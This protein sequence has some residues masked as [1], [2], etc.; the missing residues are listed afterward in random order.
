MDINEEAIGIYPNVAI[1]P[2]TGRHAVTGEP[3][4]QPKSTRIAVDLRDLPLDAWWHAMQDKKK[5]VAE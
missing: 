3:V 1:D 2:M 4:E 5:A